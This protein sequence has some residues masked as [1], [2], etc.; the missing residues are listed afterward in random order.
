MLCVR[1]RTGTAVTDD[2]LCA[3]CPVAGP[4]LPGRPEPVATGPGGWGIGTWPRSPVGLS[5]AVT[6][7]L[8][9]VIVT[10]LAAIGTGLHLRALW[11]G[12][13]EEGDPAVHGSRGVAAERLHSVAGTGQAAVF[14]ATAVVF[15]IWFH[16]TRRNAEVFD[17]GAQRM[18]PGWS[19]GGWFVPFANLWFPYRVATGVWEGSVVPGPEGGRPTVSRAPL[20]LWWAAW[21]ASSLLDSFTA[22]MEGSAETPEQTVQGLGLVVAADAFEIVS[23][24]LAI[25][26]VRTLTRMQVERAALRAPRTG[27]GQLTAP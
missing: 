10:D 18:G 8:G 22:R 9:A 27:S 5:R 23:A 24:V 16:R 19:V 7:L 1:C 14:V 21:I 13:V 2:G 15:I 3:S 20:R 25:F 12:L 11:Q 26:F 17:P 4:P 6:A